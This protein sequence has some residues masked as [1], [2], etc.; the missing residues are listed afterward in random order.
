MTSPTT[1][2]TSTSTTTTTPTTVQFVLNIPSALVDTV[3][4]SLCAAGGFTVVSEANAKQAAI[5]WITATVQNVQN[6]QA[7]AAALATATTVTPI[8]GLS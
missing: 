1:S 3:T 2:T 8:T 4:A 6:A 7:Q 5:N